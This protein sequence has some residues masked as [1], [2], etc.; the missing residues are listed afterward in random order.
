MSRSMSFRDLRLIPTLKRYNEVE[1]LHPSLDS[2]VNNCLSQIGFDMR[3]PI[4]YI[5]SKHRDLRGNVAVGFRAVG[6]VSNDRAFINSSLCSLTER[7]IAAAQTDASLAREMCFLMGN[8]IN[9][10]GED[11]GE[12]SDDFP[13]ESVE[14]DCDVVTLQIKSL[15]Q[16]R[17]VIRGSQYGEDGSLKLPGL[18]K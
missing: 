8:N 12:E 7:L 5:P 6:E 10:S 18:Y 17:D 14:S 3:Y 13:P 4:E 11:P 1:L 9:I 2:V 15:E 16:I